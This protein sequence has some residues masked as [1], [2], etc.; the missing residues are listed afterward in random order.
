MLD[1]YQDYYQGDL[2]G[3]DPRTEAYRRRTSRFQEMA[4]GDAPTDEALST[5]N[6]L[7]GDIAHGFND[8]LT[9][10]NGNSSLA[11]RTLDPGHPVRQYLLE[12]QD[13]GERAASFTRQLLEFEAGSVLSRRLGEKSSAQA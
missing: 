3:F 11:L 1:Y 5:L 12:I 4:A 2:G 13:A 9:T 7:A 10:I 6:R 8:L